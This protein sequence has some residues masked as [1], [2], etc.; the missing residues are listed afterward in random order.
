MTLKVRYQLLD[1]D[2]LRQLLEDI[3][4]QVIG[5][6]PETPVILLGIE[7]RGGPLARRLAAAIQKSSPQRSGRSVEVGALDIN[8]YRD[9]LTMVAEQPVVRKTTLPTNIDGRDLILVDDVLY[10]GRTIRAALEALNDYGRARSIR[11]AVLVDR[12]LREL[13][14][15][16]DFVGRTIETRPDEIVDVRVAEIDGEDGCWVL[17]KE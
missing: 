8:L 5:T 10:T 1:D 6:Q 17:E 15:Q 12:G 16:P 4:S 14:I 9:D 7:R 2:Q 13:P 3:A 11:L